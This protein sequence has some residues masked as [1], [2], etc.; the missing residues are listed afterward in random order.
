V[1]IVWPVEPLDAL[2]VS[3][4]DLTYGIVQPGPPSIDGVPIVRVKDVRGGRVA[5]GEPLLVSPEI[6]SAYSRSRL[7]GGELLVTLVGTAGE[8]AV[9]PP[10]LRGWNTARAIGVARIK[11]EIGANWVALCLTS[12][13]AKARIASRLNTT[14]QPTLN[15]KDL[16]EVPIPLPPAAERRGIEAMLA[17]L[18]DKIDSNRRSIALL[19]ELSATWFRRWKSHV[20]SDGVTTF[21]EIAEV[22]GGATP[23]TSVAEYWDG[24]HYWATPTDVTALSEPYLFMTQRRVTDAGLASCAVTL[25]P[26]G[27]ILMTS[28]ATIGAF[29]INTMQCAV[30]QGFVAVRPR[31]ERERWFLFEEMQSRV[32]EMRDRANGSTFM[33][34]SRGN[35]KQLPV[36]RHHVADLESLDS[37]LSPLHASAA[38]LSKESAVLAAA[39]EALLPELLSGRIRVPEADQPV[40]GRAG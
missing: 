3:S 30:N 32:G 17:A 37:S 6:E 24:Q 20:D 26:A 28:R 25:H 23:R 22:F 10:S 33:E 16:R 35:F 13:E 36:R 38:Q 8:V 4:G 18:D 1:N 14:V 40:A 21:G 19:I 2:L 15:L 31:H 34:L 5:V 11:P 29:A 39:R 27:T 7:S 9:V 12:R